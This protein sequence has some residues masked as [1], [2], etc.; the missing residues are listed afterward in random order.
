MKRLA[1][2]LQ[3]LADRDN[4]MLAYWKAAR[5]KQQRRSVQAFAADLDGSLRKL[6]ESILAGIAPLGLTRQFEIHDPKRRT[7]TAACFE[8][9]VLHHAIINLAGPR[10]E[11]A[12]APGVF[13]CR[14]GAG[15][16]AA[17]AA[18]QRAL[19]RHAWLVQVD[20]NAFF[21]NVDHAVLR[22]QIASQFKGAEFLA[23]LGRIIDS[24]S[25]APGRGLPIGALTSQ[26]FANGYLSPADRLLEG[27]AGV[28]KPIRYMDDLVW[29]CCSRA[30]AD[31]SLA[32]VRSLLHDGLKL[33]LKDRV[34]I[35]PAQQGLQFCGFRIKPG[36]ILPG[37]RKRLLYAQAV[38]RL[39][40]AEVRGT[41]QALLQRAHDVSASGLLPAQSLLMRRRAWW[42]PAQ[43]ERPVL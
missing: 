34:I 23:L 16:H 2:R 27:F 39:R 8:D 1:I 20:V 31:E 18:V 29:F 35:R 5:G 10:F 17:V 37:A 33:Q 21:P 11:R 19:R 6:G 43:P 42:G 32:A 9:R 15:V 36:V 28:S 4:L 24:G 40:A 41:P 3:D 13:A 22:E 7:I 12:L 25:V 14:S 26:H 38:A 30:V